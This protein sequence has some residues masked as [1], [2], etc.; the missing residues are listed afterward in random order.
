MN[1]ELPEDDN[2]IAIEY[3]A[4]APDYVFFDV[5]AIS[6]HIIQNGFLIKAEIFEDIFERSCC[7]GKLCG[8]VHHNKR[9]SAKFHENLHNTH[10]L[11]NLSTG[12]QQIQHL[13]AVS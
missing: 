3:Y 12:L 10:V 2:L 6:E 13:S 1:T 7:F 5:S 11:H 4:T 8:R 9:K